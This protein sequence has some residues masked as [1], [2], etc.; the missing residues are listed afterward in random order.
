[1]E[2]MV[3]KYLKKHP[4]NC[5]SNYNGLLVTPAYIIGMYYNEVS[6]KPYFFRC[7]SLQM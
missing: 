7:G 5:V 2:K 4:K 1:M 6:G 3:L